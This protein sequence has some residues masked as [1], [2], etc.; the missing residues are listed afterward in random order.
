MN[1]IILPGNSIKNKTWAEALKTALES[2]FD[3]IY[4]Q[5]YSH[6]ETGEKF[7]D[8]EQEINTIMKLTNDLKNYIIFAK[9]VGVILALKAI[10]EKKL[11]PSKCIFAGLAFSWAKL[12]NIDI[13]LLLKYY[14]IST[15]FIQNQND[16]AISFQELSKL[17]K[18]LEVRDYQLTKFS[19]NKHEYED[20]E[21][22]NNLITRFTK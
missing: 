14:G 22:L 10:S 19:G 3:S 12:Q 16:P 4:I 9:S 17:L 5:Q 1:L 11:T 20:I 7:L 8:L 15:L 13:I 21:A 18:K 2:Q 6:W